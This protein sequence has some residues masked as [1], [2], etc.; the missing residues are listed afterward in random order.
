MKRNLLLILFITLATL[1]VTA[2]TKYE[3]NVAGVEVT[4]DNANYITGGD[5]T[6][7][8]A[9]YNASSNTLTLYSIKIERTGQDKYGIHNR[10]CD[11]LRIVFNGDCNIST[12]DNALKLE[13]GTTLNAASGSNVLF[14]SSARIC[15]NL[16]S[17]S[18]YITGSGVMRFE[19]WQSAY[20][21]IK[22]EGTSS[23]NVYFEGAKVTAHSSQRSALS[24]FAA[25]MEGGADLTIEGNGS[26]ASVSNVSMSFSGNTT[27]LEPYGAYYSDNSVYSSSGNQIKSG[28]IYISDNYVALLNSY[29]FPDANFRSYL[30]D[31]YPKRYITTSDVNSRTSLSPTNKGISNLQGIGY[32][33]KLTSLDCSGNNLTSLSSLP[34]SIQT[35]YAGNNKFTNLFVN[36]R[37]S[38]KTLDVRNN[39]SLTL[40]DCSNNVLT[41]LNY[42]G[43]TTLKKLVCHNNQLTSL[44]DLPSSIQE[45]YA[46]SN[47]FTT[48]SITGKPNLNTLVVLNCFLLTQLDCSNNFLTSLDYDWC[49]ALKILNCANNKLTSLGSLPSSVT[50]LN[51]S[52]NELTTLPSLPSGLV[53]LNCASNKLTS[54][55]SLPNNIETLSCGANKFTTLTIAGYMKLTSLDVKNNTSLTMLNCYANA[56]TSLNYSGCS[57][58]KTLD[59][60]SNKLTSLGAVPSSVTKFNCSVNQLT[61]LPSLP[62]GLLELECV[63][64]KLS[65]LS[66]LGLNSLTKLVI[67]DNQIKETAMESLVN[68]MRTIPAGSMGDF[69]VLGGDGEGNVITDAQVTI[70]RNKRWIPY[71]YNGS[72][73]V[74]ITA[75]S[76]PGDVNGDGDVTGSDVTALYNYLLFNDS[77]AI[78]NGDQNGDG[79]IT[80]SDVTA[81]YNILLGL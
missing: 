46:N 62:S 64:N 60:A 1:G 22:G 63:A 26:N 13:R 33:S 56:L 29:Y 81:V 49:T 21:A 80:G 74:E 61:V 66:V 20:E 47:M 68:S 45:V 76:V 28:N 67:Y 79:D 10:K 52:T 48:L 34:S 11:N 77:S 58:L 32:F 69:R 18:Y 72:E 12:A 4:S 65:N 8:Y 17:Y 36:S 75:G 19:A 25:H 59:C 9:V 55:P 31:L 53:Y 7:G 30:V 24:S 57:A 6:S 5:I 73:W 50:R 40:L 23:T 78:V 71:K 51:C 35:L 14:Y 37:S 3:I 42:S 44:P 15:A 41:S 2:A 38:L 27:I 16:K 43:C 39:T 54:L 70:A